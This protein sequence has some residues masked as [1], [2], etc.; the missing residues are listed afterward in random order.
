VDEPREAQLTRLK[1]CDPPR[2]LG[3]VYPRTRTGSLRVSSLLSDIF[4]KD[5]SE[6]IGLL[7]L[8]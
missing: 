4:V 8:P 1:G 2:V 6:R 3:G 5:N 7:Q